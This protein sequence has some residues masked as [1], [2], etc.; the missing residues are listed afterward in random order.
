MTQGFNG[1]RPLPRTMLGA[2]NAAGDGA[3]EGR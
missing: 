3:G 1:F 2:A